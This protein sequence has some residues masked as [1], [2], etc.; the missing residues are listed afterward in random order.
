M[1][2]SQLLP[3]LLPLALGTGCGTIIH[4]SHQNIR[5]ETDPPGA[6][7]SAEDQTITTPGV[8]K[9]HRK[10]T[11]LEV[12]VEKEGYVTRRVALTRKDSGLDWTNIVFAPIGFA[13]GAATFGATTDESSVVESLVGPKLTWGAVGAV[14]MT[15]AAF[16]TDRATGAAWRLDPPT[17]VLRL[18]PVADLTPRPVEESQDERRPEIR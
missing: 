7:A 13:A 11:G 12:V 18:E 6:T 2:L 3:A 9:L 15:V 8:L 4:G 17:I 16:G 14:F 5:V 1:K 10:A